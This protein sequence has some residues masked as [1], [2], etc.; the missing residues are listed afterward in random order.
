V[1]AI[2]FPIRSRA[3]SRTRLQLRATEAVE[4]EMALASGLVTRPRP[5]Q[6]ATP[7]PQFSNHFMSKAN[8]LENRCGWRKLHLGGFPPLIVVHFGQTLSSA[9]VI[10]L[11]LETWCIGWRR[12][13]SDFMGLNPVRGKQDR[14]ATAAFFGCHRRRSW[15]SSLV[16]SRKSL[17]GSGRSRAPIPGHHRT[18][19][20]RCWREVA[21]PNGHWPV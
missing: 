4:V 21:R 17:S 5:V 3:G 2:K 10:Q 19:R 13:E 16:M 18:V 20:A 6:R 1:P 12:Q 14:T 9:Q 7:L 15:R 11:P 8:E